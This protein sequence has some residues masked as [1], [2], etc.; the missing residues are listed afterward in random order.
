MKRTRKT[1]PPCPGSHQYVGGDRVLF[2]H[3]VEGSEIH[4]EPPVNLCLLGDHDDRG[5][6]RAGGRLNES[7]PLH[8]RQ[9]L[10]CLG[11]VGQREVSGSHPNGQC[12]SSFNVWLDEI[13]S[14][15]IIL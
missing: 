15:H 13:C 7:R 12:I 11:L 2:C 10:V 6:P 1:L 4:T 9:G 3:F 8:F 5:D 14:A